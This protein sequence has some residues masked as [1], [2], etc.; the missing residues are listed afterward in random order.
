M[1]L[2]KKL[3]FLGAFLSLEC[4]ERLASHAAHRLPAFMA[5]TILRATLG[6]F[7]F[8]VQTVR[9]ASRHRPRPQPGSRKGQRWVCSY[10]QP[11]PSSK[12]PSSMPPSS[13]ASVDRLKAI[14]GAVQPSNQLV[15]RCLQRGSAG[16]SMTSHHSGN[17][18]VPFLSRR[19]PDDDAETSS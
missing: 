19:R 8:V 15:G 11:L 5:R 17:A 7:T 14:A 3:L 10:R 9:A 13:K 2:Q 4:V 16:P 12:A 6:S 1:V 18:R